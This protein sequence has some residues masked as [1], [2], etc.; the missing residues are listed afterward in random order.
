MWNHVVVILGVTGKMTDF[1]LMFVVIAILGV[2]LFS[3]V[4]NID[5]S[6]DNRKSSVI[7]I[8]KCDDEEN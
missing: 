7:S 6:S 5:F 1:I 2:F 4:L 8:E 3:L